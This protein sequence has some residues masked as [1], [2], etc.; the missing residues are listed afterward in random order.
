MIDHH[1][2]TRVAA[3]VVLFTSPGIAAAAEPSPAEGQSGESQSTPDVQQLA[4]EV[5]QKGWIVFSAKS[6]QGDYDLFLCRPNGDQRRNLTNT[7]EFTEFG[8]HFSPDGKRLLYRRVKKGVPINHDKWGEVGT[9]I[10]ANADGTDPSPQ[11]QDGEL[12]W[13][14]W[15]PDGRQ[16]A[17]LE[18]QFI[19]IRDCETKKVIQE[20]PR[21][22]IFQQLF[23]SS[24]GKR[25]CG[26]A[27]MRGRQWNVVSVE[28]ATGKATLLT[29][30][31]N[32]TPDWFQKDPE[33]VIYSNRTPG[34]ATGYGFTMLM[35]AT[36]DGKSR[37]LIYAER[38]KHIYYGCT[39]PD[40]Q[41]V[42]FARPEDDGGIDGPMALVRLADAPIVV[43]ADYQDLL[44]LYPDAK[45]GPVL[46]LSYA[47][48]EPHWTY[49]EIGGK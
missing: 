24:D 40:D 16:F 25:V 37:K 4:G 47:G 20:L 39:S 7:P 8:G 3:W 28:L 48:F 18:D 1:L 30:A 32:C 49:A 31:L 43:P 35:Y 10:V 13:A 22:G 45:P 33:R 42:I 26:T 23:W 38:G 9:L 5:A 17:C 27:N 21:E 29:R 19:R 44:E 15:G 46:R 36:A 6:E 11:G 14:S 2:L 12:P 41:Y 34:I